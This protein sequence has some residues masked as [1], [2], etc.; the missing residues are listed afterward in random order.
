MRGPAA[1][2]FKAGAEGKHCNNIRRDW[3]RKM[4]KMKYDHRATQLK[5]SPRC[6]VGLVYI[7]T[8]FKHNEIQIHHKTVTPLS[9]KDPYLLRRY[10]AHQAYIDI[11]SITVTISVSLGRFLRCPSV[12][13]MSRWLSLGK[14]DGGKLKS[15]LTCQTVGFDFSSY[16][17]LAN[18]INYLLVPSQPTGALPFKEHAVLST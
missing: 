10:L 14:R 2:L 9:C 15:H 6:K 11:V 17:S 4:A 13:L 18:P 5:V 12:G 8:M 7:C 1:N 16:L 3:F